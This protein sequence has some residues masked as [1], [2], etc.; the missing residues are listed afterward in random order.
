MVHKF[1]AIR[2]ERSI[3]AAAVSMFCILITFGAYYT[4]LSA[5]CFILNQCPP[6][7]GLLTRMY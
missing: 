2:D 6:L 3:N 1:Y 7:K 4:G 5:D